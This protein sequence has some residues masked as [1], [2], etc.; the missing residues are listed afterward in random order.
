MRMHYMKDFWFF[1]P[2]IFAMGESLKTRIRAWGSR[3][4]QAIFGV[5]MP[6]CMCMCVFV[7]VCVHMRAYMQIYVQVRMH[8]C[9]CP[10]RWLEVNPEC[11]FQVPSTFFSK[12]SSSHFTWNLLAWQTVWS[13]SPR[14]HPIS[15]SPILG[16]S[17]D[18][19]LFMRV[20]R[21]QCRSL[22]NQAIL[23]APEFSF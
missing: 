1:F 16:L 10:Y 13:V 6:A 19:Q 20:L 5:C 2:P 11:H 7:C 21:V 14:D 22:T 23:L 8:M 9:A 18:T 15:D 3:C 12:T 4:S 17:S